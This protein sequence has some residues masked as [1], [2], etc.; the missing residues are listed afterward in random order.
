MSIQRIKPYVPSRQPSQAST[1]K[2]VPGAVYILPSP[3]N[4]STNQATT[5][6]L[7]TVEISTQPQDPSTPIALGVNIPP[8]V[9]V[10]TGVG[11]YTLT[12]TPSTN[13]A[14]LVFLN[15]VL[16]NGQTDYSVSGTSLTLT[17]APT[18][19]QNNATWIEAF[20]T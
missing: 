13:G 15:G 11:P 3:P 6:S 8:D 1:I 2:T 16:L 19:D 12:R 17:S 7:G 14:M 20:Y 18:V 9:F 4:P 5:T 10:L